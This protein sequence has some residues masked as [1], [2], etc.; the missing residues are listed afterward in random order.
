MWSYPDSTN[1]SNNN[2]KS[3][4]DLVK[5]KLRRDPRSEN[6]DFYEF[7]MVLFDSGN[8]G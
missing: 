6:S 4:K 2:E 7:K 1:K 5:I 3:D 8:P